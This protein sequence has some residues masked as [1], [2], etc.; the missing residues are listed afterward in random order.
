MATIERMVEKFVRDGGPGRLGIRDGQ[1]GV[2]FTDEDEFISFA[3]LGYNGSLGFFR[4]SS[5]PGQPDEADK[6]PGKNSRARSQEIKAA[7]AAFLETRH[8]DVIGPVS[9]RLLAVDLAKEVGCH[10][11][12]ARIAIARA[13][14]RKRSEIVEERRHGGPRPGSGRPKAEK[15]G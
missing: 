10:Y 7:A 8:I 13:I 5:F 11:T 6:P 9:L 15:P 2:V 1:P 4:K 14:R 3:D 12:T